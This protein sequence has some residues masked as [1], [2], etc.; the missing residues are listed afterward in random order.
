MTPFKTLVKQAEQQS[1]LPRPGWDYE[2]L[3][4]GRE[5]RNR[6]VHGN[7]HGAL[8]PALPGTS[9]AARTRRSPR[10]SPTTTADSL[11]YLASV[12]QPAPHTEL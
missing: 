9:S 2:Q 3:D 11:R 5:F 4:A 10:S 1:L 12:V 6:V 8:P 7:Q